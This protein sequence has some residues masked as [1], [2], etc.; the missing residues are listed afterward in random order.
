[1]AKKSSRLSAAILSSLKR[2]SLQQ[3]PDLVAGSVDGICNITR[4][5]ALT[6]FNV[7]RLVQRHPPTHHSATKAPPT[8]KTTTTRTSGE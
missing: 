4:G 8:T 2:T 7:H 3:T 6:A 5:L 1:M